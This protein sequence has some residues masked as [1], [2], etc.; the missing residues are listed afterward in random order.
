M[1]SQIFCMW[2]EPWRKRARLR[3][4]HVPSDRLGRKCRGRGICERSGC[5]RQALEGKAPGGQFWTAAAQ[6]CPKS[7]CTALAKALVDASCDS[8]LT[9]LWDNC[10]C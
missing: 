8:R 4:W 3:L 7:L 2:G 6:P 1:S 9:R 10:K 5:R